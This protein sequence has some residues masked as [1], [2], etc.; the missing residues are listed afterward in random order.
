MATTRPTYARCAAL[1]SPSSPERYRREVG[2]VYS[3]GAPP[4]FRG[5]LHYYAV[6]HDLRGLAAGPRAST[7]G[8]AVHVLTGEYAWSSPPAQGEAAAAA[9]EGATFTL[10]PGLGHFPMCEN[11]VRFRELILPLLTSISTT[12]RAGP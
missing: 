11:P 9:I 8:T 5:D 3:Q 12:A 4:V 6:D 10:M 1:T 7:G 2:W